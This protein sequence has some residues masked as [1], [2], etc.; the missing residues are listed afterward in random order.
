MSRRC[1]VL[2]SEPRTNRREQRERCAHA[3]RGNEDDQARQEVTSRR[4]KRELLHVRGERD[5]RGG[6]DTEERRSEEAEA[7]DGELHTSVNEERSL[8]SA[9][10]F[11]R[12]VS[13]QGEPTHEGDQHRTR[14]VRGRS[15][16]ERQVLGKRNLV[17]EPQPAGQQV[18]GGDASEGSALGHEMRAE[19]A[20]EPRG[21]SNLAKRYRRGVSAGLRLI[22]FDRTCVNG[23]GLGLSR[24]WSSGSR[25]YSL[26]R[27]SDGAYGARNFADGLAWASSFRPSERIAE[28]Q[29]WGHGKWG[30][31]FIAKESLDRGALA[32]GH[33]HLALCALRERLLPNALVWFRT[34]ETFGAAA[35]HDFAR[36]WTD[37]FGMQ[38]GGPHLRDRVLAERSASPSARRRAIVEQG[39]RFDP[40]S[41]QRP[42]R[43]AISWPGRPNTITCLQGRVPEGW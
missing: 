11:A 43:A 8:D 24:A 39:R 7:A 32:A 12:E 41:A 14:R 33:H 28:L 4:K 10:E 42:E 34:C 6:D 40:G 23:A 13:A 27:R 5:V 22:L 35:G 20:G 16:H 18:E 38:G 29:F 9:S 31:I 21:M 25:L 36:A 3:C 17:Q 26:L 19:S 37:F 30:R 2:P 15:E 1:E